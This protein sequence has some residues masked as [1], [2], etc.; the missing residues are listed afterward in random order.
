VIP[1]RRLRDAYRLLY[2]YFS[3]AL[4][5][6]EFEPTGCNLSLNLIAIP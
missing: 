5:T 6:W 4:K 1:A 3:E 2:D